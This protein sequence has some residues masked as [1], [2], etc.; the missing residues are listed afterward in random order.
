MNVHQAFPSRFLKPAD[1]AGAEPV[2]TI[3]RVEMEAIGRDKARTPVLYFDGK[4]KGLVLNRTIANRIAELV[5]DEEMDHWPGQRIR[6]YA[7]TTSF[8]GR[9]VECVRVKAAV[10]PDRAVGSDATGADSGAGG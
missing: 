8:A 2:V 6:L 10:P 7:T 1:L 3:A 5:T 9:P 4:R